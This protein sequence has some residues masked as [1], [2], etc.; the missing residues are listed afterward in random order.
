MCHI[1]N[2]V[3]VC[4]NSV[5]APLLEMQTCSAGLR[6]QCVQYLNSYDL[7]Q[8][9]VQREYTTYANCNHADHSIFTNQANFQLAE[10]L[11]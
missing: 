6:F 2:V 8:P 11:W 10:N 3:R 5:P 4:P 9:Q 1:N 7:Q